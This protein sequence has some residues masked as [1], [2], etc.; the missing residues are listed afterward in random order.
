MT[1]HE[2]AIKI[3][4]MIDVR[5]SL[6]E[7]LNALIKVNKAIYLSCKDYTKENDAVK[8]E[9]YTKSIRSNS[10][11]IESLKNKIQT[12]DKQIDELRADQLLIV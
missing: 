3:S 8:V 6:Q 9:R 4:E 12:K 11:K 5:D 10:R 1:S 2:R 7:E